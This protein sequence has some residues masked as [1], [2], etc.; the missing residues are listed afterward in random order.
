MWDHKLW[1]ELS[2]PYRFNLYI[3][4]LNN[5]DSEE[6][7]TR[8]TIVNCADIH[9][10]LIANMFSKKKIDH[11]I[12]IEKS[13]KQKQKKESIGYFNVPGIGLIEMIN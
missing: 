5:I 3:Y 6:Q 9:G 4:L 12:K 2:N 10:T 8:E 11:I 13:K 1:D 7:K